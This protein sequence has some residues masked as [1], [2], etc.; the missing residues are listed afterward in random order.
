MFQPKLSPFTTALVTGTLRVVG[1]LTDLDHLLVDAN[2]DALRLSLFDYKVANEAQIHIALDRHTI[3]VDRDNPIKL[4]GQDT[5]LDLSGTVGLH[6]ERID[7]LA[8]GSA[9]LGILQGFFREI[10]SSGQAELIANLQGPLYTPLFSGSA[11]LT[12]GRLRVVSGSTP[13]PSLTAING[14]LSFDA[15][16]IRVDDVVAKLGEGDVR[17]RRPHHDGRVS[18]GRRQ[19]DCRRREH[20]GSGLSAEVRSLVDAELSLVGRSTRAAADGHRQRQR[21][22]LGQAHRHVEPVPADGWWADGGG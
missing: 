3:R 9:N 12:N 10:R 4:V 5:K 17:F 16:A 13:L 18:A 2:I 21:R 15:R 1:E 22:R 20:A 6:D 8:T 11:T 7:V 19:P 14:R